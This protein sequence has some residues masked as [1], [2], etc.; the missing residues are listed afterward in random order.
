[1]C[2]RDRRTAPPSKSHSRPPPGP[3]AR[4]DNDVIER[5]SLPADMRSSELRY[6]RLFEEAN[7][8]IVLADARTRKITQANPFVTDLLGMPHEE[9]VGRDDAVVRLLE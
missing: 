8:G 5:S 3:A 4:R 6:R 7:Y 1:M 2:I 9:I